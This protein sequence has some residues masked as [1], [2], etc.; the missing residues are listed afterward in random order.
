MKLKLKLSVPSKAINAA[1]L[2]TAAD[3]ALSQGAALA[4]AKLARPTSTWKH[5]APMQTSVT[6]NTATAGTNDAIYGYVSQ[7]TRPHVIVAKNAGGLAFGPSSPKTSVGSLNAGGGSR[8]PRT[9]IRPRVNHPGTAPRKFD[10]AAADELA[11]EWPAQ[12]QRL[13]D[14]ASNG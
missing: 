1:R 11:Q 7:G 3:D 9:T 12:V 8:G 4:A 2:R 10:Q 14:E 13:L 5:S 6:G